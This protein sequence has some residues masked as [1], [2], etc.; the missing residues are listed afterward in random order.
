LLTLFPQFG[1]VSVT[2]YN[3]SSNFHSLQFQVVKRFTKGLSLN[4]SYTWSREHLKNQYL[5]PQDTELTDYISPNERPNRWTFSAIYEL[6]FGKGRSWG[7]DWHPVVDDFLGGWQIQGIY[8]WQSGEPLLLPNAF[9]NGDPNQLESKLGKKDDQG[10]RYGVD[11]PAW[12]TSG[13]AVSGTV[14][15]VGNNYTSSNAVTLRNF[16]LTVDGL[17]NQ[18]FLKFDVGISK[19]FRIREGMKFQFRVDAI[20]LLNRPYFSS[21][22]VTPSNSNFGFTSAPVR[23]PPRDIQIGGRFTF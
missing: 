16:P 17:R 9:F 4:G 21:P 1:N 15:G 8:E 20:N 12:D 3:G 14:P 11:I 22:N 19:N 2:E 23:Q 10:R 7:S 6:P 18:R 13:F 5:N